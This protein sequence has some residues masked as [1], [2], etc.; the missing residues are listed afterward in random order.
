MVI[1]KSQIERKRKNPFGVGFR[2]VN[3]LGTNVPITPEGGRLAVHGY[4]DQ[5]DIAFKIAVSL[6]GTLL[7]AMLFSKVLSNDRY[8]KT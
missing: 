5:T 3:H 7:I 6:S 2:T 4:M 8:P 1:P